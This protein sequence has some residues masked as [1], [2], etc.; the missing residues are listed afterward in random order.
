MP[1]LKICW[2][3][4]ISLGTSEASSTLQWLQGCLHWLHFSHFLPEDGDFS[5]TGTPKDFQAFE[6]PL[7]SHN[8][9]LQ[10]GKGSFKFLRK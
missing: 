6:F 3:N 10:F 4:F 9:L 2:N 1:N 5:K 7:F 8:A